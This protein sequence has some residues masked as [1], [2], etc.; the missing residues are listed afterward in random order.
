MKNKVLIK[1][2]A[3]DL[4]LNFDVFI[5][6]NELIWKVEKLV[7]KSISD[8]TGIPDIINN[9]YVFLNKTTSRIYNSNEIVLNTDIRNGT[10]LVLVPINNDTNTSMLP[11]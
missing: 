1:I 3:L 4:N 8:I 10:E 5:P 9:E 7:I 2:T 11:I 6:V